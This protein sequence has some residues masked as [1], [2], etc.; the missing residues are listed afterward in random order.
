[1]QRRES[2][3]PALWPMLAQDGQF[4]FIVELSERADLTAADRLP[5]KA[6][7]GAFVFSALQAAA[8]NSQ[9]ELLTELSARGLRHRPFWIIN[10]ILVT[11]DAAA[12][13]DLAGH[14]EVAY[15]HANPAF[16]SS[17]PSP[18]R[19]AADAQAAGGIEWN[20]ALIG[21]PQLWAQA[22]D[23]HDVVIGGQDTGYDWDHPAIKNQYRGW[24]G[25]S[26]SHDYNWHDAIHSSIGRCYADSPF[27][28]DDH[29]HGTHTMGTMVGDDDDGNQI[30]VA[31]GARW[32]GCRNM[33]GG[34]G[35]PATYIECF[36]WFVAPTEIGGSNP[37]PAKAPD[38][39]NN[40]W[41]CPPYEG[42]TEPD[43]LQQA[44]EAVRAAGILTVQSAGN[45]G[46]SCASINTPAAIYDASFTVGATNS[47]DQIASF[48]ARGPVLV[49][50]SS[51]AK[52]DVV[53]P[54]VSIRSSYPGDSY[55][56]LS[57]TSMSGPHV[58]GLAA[59]L[60]SASPDLAGDVDRIETAI[61]VT[62]VRL[63]SDQDCFDL[64][65]DQLPNA[66][67]GYGRVDAVAAVR[68]ATGPRY[69]FPIAPNN[70]P[71]VPE[72]FPAE[73]R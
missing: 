60:I 62:S 33:D 37:D 69:W 28:C 66:V 19:A 42:C 59:L 58:A 26:A 36:Q 44:V 4:D 38:I 48:S 15:I 6:A 53:A 25:Q 32:I 8:A 27:P 29:G 63:Y 21:A 9:Q 20:I 14:P 51:R 70:G 23:G 31:P 1:M 34:V 10:A 13:R 12:L 73:G 46:P 22:I 11:G 55:M 64:P 49:D 35:T 56:S 72:P 54:G 30:G 16:E 45:S 52:P 40:S 24:D 2:I 3:D 57:G 39:I 43:I 18:D 61:T 65:G 71:L 67:F 7:K 47:A 17:L 5:T 41:S 68:F 50:G